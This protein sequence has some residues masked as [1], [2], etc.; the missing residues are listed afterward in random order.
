MVTDLLVTKMVAQSSMIIALVT[1]RSV[2][3]TFGHKVTGDSR[4]FG[5]KWSQNDRKP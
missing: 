3:V 4:F 1:R 5:P 2:I